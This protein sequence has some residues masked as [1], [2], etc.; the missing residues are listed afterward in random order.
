MS[1][2]VDPI[3][4]L[5]LHHEMSRKERI[6]AWLHPNAEEGDRFAG[7]PFQNYRV[8]RKEEV[9]GEPHPQIRFLIVL[10]GE[11]MFLP[12]WTSYVPKGVPPHLRRKW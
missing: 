9:P 12:Q 7:A 8:L 3:P 6:W 10:E 5:V 11:K 4:F 1:L 2:F